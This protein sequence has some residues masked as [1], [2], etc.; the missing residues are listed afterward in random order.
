MYLT[1]RIDS[2]PRREKAKKVSIDVTQQVQLIDC[3][4]SVSVEGNRAVDSSSGGP[5]RPLV[6]DTFRAHVIYTY[7]YYVWQFY[8]FR[9]DPIVRLSS[10]LYLFH[11][12]FPFLSLSF[13]PTCFTLRTTY[14]ILFTSRTV[15]A[16]E[17]QCRVL[18][19]YLDCSL[20]IQS[21]DF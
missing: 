3:Y 20:F 11:L 14:R 19:K 1:E 16:L 4:L 6:S 10:S 2:I 8:Q 15:H 18:R 17:I 21:H 5:V 12:S 9:R 7:I 13:S